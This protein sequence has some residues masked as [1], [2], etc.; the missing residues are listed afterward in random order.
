MN[1]GLLYHIMIKG[2]RQAG[3]YIQA[4]YRS[5]CVLYA[6]PLTQSLYGQEGGSIAAMMIAL[7]VPIYNVSAVLILEYFGGRK[8]AM[9]REEALNLHRLPS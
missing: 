8:V 4:V 6:L 1:F 5:N 9:V 2:K 3:S 7:V